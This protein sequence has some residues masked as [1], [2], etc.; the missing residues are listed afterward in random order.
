MLIQK[1]KVKAGEMALISAPKDVLA[2]FKSFKPKTSLPPGAKQ[3]FDFILLFAAQA[4]ELENSWKKTVSALKEDATLWIAY[5]KKS[6][7]IPSDLAGMSGWKVQEGSAWQPVTSISI[8]ETWTG[9][10]FKYAPNLES[11]RKERLSEEVRDID[12]TVVVDRVNRVVQPSRD[13]EQVLKRHAEAKAFFESLSFTNKK[14]YVVWIVEAKRKETRDSR[15][16]SALEK[17]LSK[18]K[19]PSE[20]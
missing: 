6:S 4:R 16:A 13:F 20:K 14:E 9:I 2:D 15:L 7:G 17:L 10:R 3:R 12:G 18:K 19:N 5:P 11:E 8:N 1:L